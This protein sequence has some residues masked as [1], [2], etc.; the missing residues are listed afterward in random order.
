[1]EFDW[2]NPPFNLDPSLSLGL[3]EE[4][5]EDP[6]AVRLLPDSPRFEVQAR[7]F[8]LGVAASGQGIFTVYRT[9]G[10]LAR[11]IFARLFE[12]EEEFLYQRRL[13][14]ALTQ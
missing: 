9:N 6:F 10:K 1:M 5:F 4:S 8:N 11:V 13:S 12:P 2:N 14:R 3:I 7:F